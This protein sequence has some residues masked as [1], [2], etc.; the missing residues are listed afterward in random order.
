MA[1]VTSVLRKRNAALST[2]KDI[3]SSGEHFKLP[4]LTISQRA[5]AAIP[6]TLPGY[7]QSYL[8]GY[9]DANM[10][11][12][13]RQAEFRYL[14]GDTWV[15]AHDLEY[16]KD[17]KAPDTCEHSGH[18]AATRNPAQAFFWKGTDKVFYQSVDMIYGTEKVETSA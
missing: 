15:N 2:I 1:T 6:R 17:C 3:V 18:I 9:L 14:I 10:D 11:R 7:A 16:G 8:R 5:N 12:L 13:Q 4:S